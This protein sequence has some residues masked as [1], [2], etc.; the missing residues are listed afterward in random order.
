M[1][2]IIFEGTPE[3]YTA[4]FGKNMGTPQAAAPLAEGKKGVKRKWRPCIVETADG[5]IKKYKSAKHAFRWY[6]Q[7]SG[8]DREHWTYTTFYAALKK[9]P[10]TFADASVSLLA[11]GAA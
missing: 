3:E 4:V 2:V 5:G 9:G 6:Q 11:G 10:V 1:K 7:A 8:D